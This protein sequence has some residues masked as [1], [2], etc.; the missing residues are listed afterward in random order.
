M[1]K[2]KLEAEYTEH[3]RKQYFDIKEENQRLWSRIAKL[4]ADKTVLVEALNKVVGYPWDWIS[5]D[6]IAKDA[7][8]AVKESE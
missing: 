5:Y 7:L 8:E 6:K 3:Y 2:S 4:E 1:S